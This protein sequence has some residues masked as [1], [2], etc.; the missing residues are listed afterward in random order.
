MKHRY[1]AVPPF[2]QLSMPEQDLRVCAKV[3]RRRPSIKTRFA[4]LVT[5]GGAV[6]LTAYASR[7]MVEVVSISGTMTYLQ[8][9][10]LVL[11]TITFG[12]IALSA[13]AAEAGVLFGGVRRR[14][15]ADA[16]IESRTALVMPVYNEDPARCFA[17]LQAMATSLLDHGAADGFEIFVLSD[18]T[19][20]DVWVKET[21]ALQM[22]RDALGDGMRV[23]YRRRTENVNRKAGNVQDFV[24]RWGGRYDFMIVLDADSVLSADTLLTMV[25]EM[26]ADSNLGLLQT[27]PRLIGGDTLLARLM[28]FAG[29]VYG[30]I[31]ARGIAAW[32]GD[33]GN[34]WGHNAII[35]TSAF[36]AAAGWP[37]LPGL[38]PFGCFIWSND[39][40]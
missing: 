34:Y 30:P 25:R 12:W 10:M 5:F 22:L 1:A 24:T 14:A 37:L 35:R 7:E 26:A 19:K 3:K 20:P 16:P 8:G 36:A 31:V 38:K 15:R 17:S 11:F 23:W 6:A 28:Q 29:T 2:A 18:T 40:V 27:V 9:L 33:D 39:F 32:Q 4:R 21:A 13:S